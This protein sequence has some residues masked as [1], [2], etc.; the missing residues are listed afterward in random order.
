MKVGAFIPTESKDTQGLQD[1]RIS[2]GKSWQSFHGWGHQWAALKGRGLLLS[3]SCRSRIL[4]WLKRVG[5][6]L[7]QILLTAQVWWE[8]AQAR[9]TLTLSVQKL[10]RQ[11]MSERFWIFL[12][13][14]RRKGLEDEGGKGRKGL[15]PT[16]HYCLVQESWVWVHSRD[17]QEGS[18]EKNPWA[19]LEV[20]PRPGQPLQAWGT[21]VASGSLEALWARSRCLRPFCLPGTILPYGES[22]RGRRRP[23]NS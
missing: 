21:W 2:G 12:T 13:V 17:A 9:L 8:R 14:C 10:L 7:T 15:Q 11:S 20:T 18:G 23:V 22:G 3:I 4:L 6:K 5:Q 1:R 16:P 19:K